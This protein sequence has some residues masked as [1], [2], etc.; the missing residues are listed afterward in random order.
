[1]ETVRVVLDVELLRE[2]DKAAKREK[3]NRSALI[4]DALAEHLKR[5]HI[6]DLEERDRLGYLGEPQRTEEYRLWEDASVWPDS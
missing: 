5:L 3:V 4:R 1:M 2:A 6:R